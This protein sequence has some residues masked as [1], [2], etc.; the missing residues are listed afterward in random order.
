MAHWQS[1]LAAGLFTWGVTA[2]GA[3]T[4]IFFSGAAKQVMDGMLG[5]GAG[6]M[7]A[8][9]FFSLLS[10]GI[11]LSEEL[12]SGMKKYTDKWRKQS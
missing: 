12:A 3:G 1:A 10:P 4:V 6:V 11:A 7:I 5:F 9:S 2:L 8:S